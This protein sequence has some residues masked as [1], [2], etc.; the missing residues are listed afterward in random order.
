VVAVITVQADRGAETATPEELREITNMYL[1]PVFKVGVW[2]AL[3]LGGIR[4]L[5][6]YM[7][8]MIQH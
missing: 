8:R 7:H 1:S 3:R 2:K 5:P 4:H 6:L